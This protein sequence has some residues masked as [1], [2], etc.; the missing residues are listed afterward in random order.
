MAT[1]ESRAELSKQRE[2]KSSYQLTCED[3]RKLRLERSARSQCS[4]SS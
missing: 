3:L 4:D 2:K 1:L